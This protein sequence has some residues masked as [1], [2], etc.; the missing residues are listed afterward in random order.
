[1]QRAR[2]GGMR[3]GETLQG[4]PAPSSAPLRK[5][6]ACHPKTL[7]VPEEET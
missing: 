7:I 2:V 1:M 3:A 5:P 4:G 6:A